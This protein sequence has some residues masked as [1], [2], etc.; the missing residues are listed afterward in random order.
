MT[1][2]IYR[3]FTRMPASSW[4]ILVTLVWPQIALA[5]HQLEHELSDQ[6]AESCAICVKLDYDDGITPPSEL[7]CPYE[8]ELGLL[9]AGKWNNPT[10]S[11]VLYRSRA[12]P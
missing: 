9:R 12:S 2:R 8:A 6:V 5:A 1:T 3:S 11:Y 10:E 4:L 7:A